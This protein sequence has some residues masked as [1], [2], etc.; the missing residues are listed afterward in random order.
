MVKKKYIYKEIRNGKRRSYSN[1][2]KK[3]SFGR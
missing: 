2:W 3:Q 1:D